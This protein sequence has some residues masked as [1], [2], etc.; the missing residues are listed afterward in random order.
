MT[1]AIQRTPPLPLAAFAFTVAGL[2][3][4]P[5]LYVSYL[6]LSADFTVWS[7]LWATRIPEL[8][9]NTAWLAVGV[10]AGSLVLGVTL[11]WL[12]VRFEFPGRRVWEWALV[13]PLA[14]HPTCSHTSIPICSAPEGLLKRR[15]RRWWDRKDGCFPPR[16]TQAQR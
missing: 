13:L 5:L 14:M 6:A 1:T 3:T 16:V 7:R 9:S 2:I 15:G 11:A 4:L 8:L 10:A 12:V